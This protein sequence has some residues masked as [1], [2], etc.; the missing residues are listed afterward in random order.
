VETP[1]YLPTALDLLVLLSPKVKK[2]L[3]EREEEKNTFF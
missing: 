1:S 3:L 2:I